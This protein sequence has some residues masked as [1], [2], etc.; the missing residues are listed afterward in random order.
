[1]NE[2]A[3]YILGAG[4]HAK[5][6]LESLQQDPVITVVGF[7]EANDQLVGGQLLGLP[8]YHQNKISELHSKKTFLV[9]GIGSIGLSLIRAKQFD[10]YKKFGFRFYTVQH[11]TS[12]TAR[13]VIIG[14]GVQLMARSTVMIGSKIGDNTIVN[15]AVSVDHDC[16]IGKHVHIA[17]GVVLSGNV[18]VGDYTHIGTG[19]NIIQGVNIGKHVLIAAGAVVVTDIPDNSRVAGVPAR[20]MK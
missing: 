19:A 2:I 20:K 15:T 5:V 4:G 16:D 3:T 13:E 18:T 11:P 9:N 1:M 6:L 7:F 10:H 8:I 12:Y 14:E 17:P